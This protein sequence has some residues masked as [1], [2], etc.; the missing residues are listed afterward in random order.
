MKDKVSTYE[1]FTLEDFIEEDRDVME[2]FQ[3][4]ECKLVDLKPFFLGK[5]KLKKLK[6]NK[7]F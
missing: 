3:C 5:R 1:K 2:A 6:K 4:Q 7:T